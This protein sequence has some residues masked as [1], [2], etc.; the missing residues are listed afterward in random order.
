MPESTPF[1]NILAESRDLVC[2]R[3]AAAMAGML[4]KADD[5]LSTMMTK[6]Q[7]TEAQ[8]LFM[9]TRDVAVQ[10]RDLIEKEFQDLFLREYRE[11]CNKVKKTSKSLFG[12]DEPEEASLELELVGD[13]DLNETLKFNEMAAKLRRYCEEELSALDQRV[14]VLLG[15]ADLQSDDNPFSPQA[16]CDAYKQTCRTV[17]SEGHVRMVLLRLFDDHVL[18]DIRSVYKDLNELLVQNSI[19]PK[20][21]YGVTRKEGGKAPPH[22]GQPEEESPEEAAPPPE[23]ALPSG[24]DF[25]AMMQKL[26]ASGAGGFMPP[27]G[28]AGGAAAGSLQGTELMGS[29]TR[30][31]HGDVSAVTEGS[32]PAAG[33]VEAGTTNVLRELKATNV[34]AGMGQMDA[35]TLDIVTLLFD[36]LFDDPKV[37]AEVKAL[38]GRLQIPM[39]KVALVDKTL[40]SRKDHPAR[41]LLD[42]IGEISLRLPADFSTTSPQY[43]R[44]ETILH[45]LIVGYEDK[46]DIF[47]ATGEKLRAMVAEAD[48]RATEEAQAAAKIVEQREKLAVSRSIAQA[49]IKSRVL[50]RKPARPVLAFLVQQWIKFLL[51]VHVQSG[52]DSDAWK[53]AL[54][55]MDLLMWSAEPKT[56]VED[57]RK[58]ATSVPS[59]LKRITAGLA[60]AGIEDAIRKSF[61]GDLMKLHTNAVGTDPKEKAPEAPEPGPP[62]APPK[63]DSTPAAKPAAG[64]AKSLKPE[65]KP[66]GKPVAAPPP[67]PE[68]DELDFTAE[69]VVVNPFGG[70]EVKVD[71]L[72]F[73]EAAPTGPATATG[74]APGAAPSA[75]AAPPKAIPKDVELPKK[76]QEGVWVAFRAKTPDEPRQTAKLEYVSPLKSRYLFVDRKGKPVLECNRTEL[77]RRFRLR[78]LVILNESPDTSLFDRIMTGVMGKLRGS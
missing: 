30:I 16:I 13:D 32:L 43:A 19:L 12:S 38:S 70:G 20:I 6:T 40:F 21:R 75:G 58:L 2:E 8:K 67:K 61:F 3:L 24:Q 23:A 31:Q 55:T 52:K 73:T 7:D 63:P 56:T 39:L 60:A 25:F 47:D 14:G 33:V 68:A 64:A 10:Q 72:D 42:T 18:D 17:S 51:I 78:D 5:S 54:E 66:A 26:M 65:P 41:V 36:Q 37:P 11:R 57:R 48:Q 35:M 9:E 1:D 45:D 46:M 22:P 34:G 44:M 59:L 74:P 69:I 71:E 76:L 53:G 28:A 4:D 62:V 15:D 77:S 29:L 50:A 49:E 27:G